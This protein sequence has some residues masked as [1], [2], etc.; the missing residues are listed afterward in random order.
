MA[1]ERERSYELKR[2]ADE[3]KQ[4]VKDRMRRAELDKI[5]EDRAEK[6]GKEKERR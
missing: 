5:K 6:E 4:K 3:K 1:A 2:I